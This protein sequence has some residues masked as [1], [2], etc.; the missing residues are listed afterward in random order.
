MKGALNKIN[1]YF[2]RFFQ[3]G[4]A[5]SLRSVNITTVTASLSPQL[6][7]SQINQSLSILIDQS[8]SKYILRIQPNI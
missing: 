4:V 7:P 1:Y 3:A 8:R 2:Y 6:L 5:D